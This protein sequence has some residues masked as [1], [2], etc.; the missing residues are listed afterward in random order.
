MLTMRLDDG[1]VDVDSGAAV[2]AGVLAKPD[3]ADQVLHE[4]VVPLELEQPGRLDHGRVQVLASGDVYTPA[5]LAVVGERVERGVEGRKFPRRGPGIRPGRRSAR[6]LLSVTSSSAVRSRLAAVIFSV[7]TGLEVGDDLPRRGR[8]SAGGPARAASSICWYGLGWLA[9]AAQ[10]GVLHLIEL[11]PTLRRGSWGAGRGHRRGSLVLGAAD[12]LGIRA[13]RRL[14]NA[15]GTL[16]KITRPVGEVLALLLEPGDEGPVGDFFVGDARDAR[17]DD[18]H[19]VVD[20]VGRDLVVIGLGQPLL[21][22]ADLG[23]PVAAA[24]PRRRQEEQD[25][26]PRRRRSGGCS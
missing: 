1:L 4:P 19:R 21:I 15:S 10:E 16:D 24:E 2:G 6:S 25:S 11:G 13:R 9:A 12:A 22:G 5:A 8:R 18:L 26:A 14:L 17:L 3:G 7:S 20:L 23:A